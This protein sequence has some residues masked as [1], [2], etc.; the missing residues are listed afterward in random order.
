MNIR[1]FFGHKQCCYDLLVSWWTNSRVSLEVG[2]GH[3][4]ECSALR[5]DCR[6]FPRFCSPCVVICSWYCSNA[7]IEN[8]ISTQGDAELIWWRLMGF[9]AGKWT[10]G[11]WMPCDMNLL[12]SAAVPGKSDTGAGRPLQSRK[13]TSTVVLWLAE[14][15]KRRGGSCWL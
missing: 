3:V 15:E 8:I 9:M 2:V 14:V 6:P 12:G 1:L 5:D 7:L 4:C 13:K 11:P 10:L